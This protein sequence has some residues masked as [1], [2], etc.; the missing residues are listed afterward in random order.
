MID[1]LVATGDPAEAEST[2][3]AAGTVIMAG[4][5]RP[6][7][8]ATGLGAT[9]ETERG[10]TVGIRVTLPGR[11]AHDATAAAPTTDVE[12]SVD[13]LR[14]QETAVRTAPQLH[15]PRCPKSKT[16]KRKASECRRCDFSRHASSHAYC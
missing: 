5:A 3:V 15:T 12:M 9:T 13:V 6:T 8:A 11:A 14:H 10:T 2:G 4:V 7:T 16:R 1:A